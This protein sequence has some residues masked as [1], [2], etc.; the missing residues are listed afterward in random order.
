MEYCAG[1]AWFRVLINIA[2]HMEFHCCAGYEGTSVREIGSVVHDG[3]SFLAKVGEIHVP[4][5]QPILC[6]CSDYV[7][8]F[9]KK[10]FHSYCVYFPR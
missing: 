4:A 6:L 9:I 1:N 2:S 8:L 3:A 7:P 10:R 5:T